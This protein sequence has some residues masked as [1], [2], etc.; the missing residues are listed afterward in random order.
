MHPRLTAAFRY[1]I[2]VYQVVLRLT[3]VLFR[4]RRIS[5][6]RSYHLRVEGV[7][8]CLKVHN[9]LVFVQLGQRDV[10]VYL[11]GKMDNRIVGRGRC[12]SATQIF[13]RLFPDKFT[14]YLSNMKSRKAR[15]ST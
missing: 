11:G 15:E 13:D 6:T 5:I 10:F 7:S 12:G 2:E 4:S 3:V 9:I 8:I 14:A 1:D